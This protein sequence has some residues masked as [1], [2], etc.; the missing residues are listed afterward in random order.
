[1]KN[2]MKESGIE[3]IGKIPEC[4]KIERYKNTLKNIGKSYFPAGDAKQDGVFTFFVSGKKTKKINKTNLKQIAILLST[5]GSFNV[6]FDKSCNAAYSTDVFALHS[7]NNNLRYLYYTIKYQEDV[8]NK[9][10]FLGTGIKHLQKKSFLSHLYCVPPLE[11]QKQIANFLDDN[12][13]IIDSKIERNNKKISLFKEYR[14]AI[15]FETVT[16]GLDKTAKM[17][18]SGIDWIG[19]IPEGW[20]VK[21]IKNIFNLRM[22]E[23]I[24]KEELNENGTI[25]VYSATAD[26]KFFGFI[27]KANFLLNVGDIVIP[28][29]GNSIGCVKMVKEIATATQTTMILF[30]NNNNNRYF[31]YFLLGNKKNLFPSSGTAI[32]QITITNIKQKS[33]LN[34]PLETQKQISDFLDIE[35]ARVDDEIEKLS[36]KNI[37]LEELKKS[38]IFE[39]VS[40]KIDINLEA[41]KYSDL[42]EKI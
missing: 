8:L 11:T 39:A 42:I 6:H 7:N 28:A 33:I 40:G 4:W 34:P 22:G 25:P 29:R 23:T 41:Q 10:F 12:T 5:G 16:K 9:K 18:D 24:L 38:L 37:L 36:K 35:T 13:S 3:W 21:R 20:K 32:P 1:M 27:N 19:D 17:K 26:D 31:Y 30:N 15:I 2:L 14:D